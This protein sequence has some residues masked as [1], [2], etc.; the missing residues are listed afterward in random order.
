MRRKPCA[1][2]AWC[3]AVTETRQGMTSRRHF[4]ALIPV[5][6]AGALCGRRAV[7]QTS[8]L[9]ESD[10]MAV[11]VGYV[12]DATRVDPK[13]YTKYQPG[14]A[15]TGCQF[16]LARPTEAWGP[17]TIFPRKLVAGKGWCDAFA[18]RPVKR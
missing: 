4:I 11:A 9:D 5:A 17:C 10:P 16:Y 3:D 15:C 13:R 2:L 1:A 14:Q 8:R 6:S 7:A 18:T 12:A